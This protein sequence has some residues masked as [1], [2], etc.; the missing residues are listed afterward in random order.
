MFFELELALCEK[1]PSLSPFDIRR[2]TLYDVFLL[3]RRMNET[4]NKE[5]D[6]TKKHYKKVNGKTRVYVPVKE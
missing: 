4:K 2:E 1:F 5:N 3:V 6:S